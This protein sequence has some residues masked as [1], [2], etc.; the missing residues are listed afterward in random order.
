MTQLRSTRLRHSSKKRPELKARLLLELLEARNLLASPPPNVLVNNPAEDG[1]D[2]TQS[3]TTIIT[4]P[5]SPVTVLV[6]YNDSEEYNAGAT[7]HFTGWSSS[8]DGGTSFTDQGALPASSKGDVGDPVLARDTKSGN[9][10]LSTIPFSGN[11][12]QVFKSTNG[13]ASFNTPVVAASTVGAPDKPWITVDNASGKGQGNLYVTFTSFAST[14]R[15]VFTKSTNAGKSFTNVTTIASGTVQ[16]S[17]VVVGTDHH[18]HIFWLQ[19]GNGTA[20]SIQEVTSTNVGK[21][22]GAATTVVSL[23]ATGING[24]LGLTATNG[25]FGFRSNTFPQ[26]AVNPVS[27]NIYVVYDDVGVA[28]GDKA[29]V[30]FTESTNGGSTWTTPVKLND[31]TTT[32]DQW[33][34]AV[35]VTPDGSHVGVFWYDRRNDPTN[36]ALIDRYG[37]IGTVSGSTVAFGANF[38]VTTTNFPAVFGSDPYV[39][40][41]YMGDYDTAAADNANFYTS[42]GDNRLSTAPDVMYATVAISTFAGPAALVASPFYNGPIAGLT[43]ASIE[44]DLPSLVADLAFI[45]HPGFGSVMGTSQPAFVT[46]SSSHSVTIG[47]S[48]PSS[49]GA[50]SPTQLSG[51]SEMPAPQHGLS[52]GMDTGYA[53]ESGFSMSS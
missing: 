32:T 27:G 11:G 41:I 53:G 8:T 16:G 28:A 34:P 10:Y 21:S 48:G 23:N 51:G 15:I 49:R 3:E 13:G 2:F 45:S 43:N 31:D 44:G 30:F 42:W 1:T 24:D 22:F 17:N 7:N 20:A 47:S 37:V 29:D 14:P 35:A 38:R 40:S 33:L 12:V 46:T 50:P 4:V 25:G 39:N 5:T 26:A 19:G 36:D 6:G 9:I 18:I 52:D